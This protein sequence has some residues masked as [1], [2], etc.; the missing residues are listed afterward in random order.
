MKASLPSY[1]HVSLT[2]DAHQAESDI[3]EV[4]DYACTNDIPS[5][6]GVDES[7]LCLVVFG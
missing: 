3:V 2:H 4:F 6:L 1:T 5:S 7:M